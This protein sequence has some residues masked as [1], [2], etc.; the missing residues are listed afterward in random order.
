[1]MQ[2]AYLGTFRGDTYLECHRE[3]SRR[4]PILQ[5]FEVPIS[6]FSPDE[7]LDTFEAETR[8]WK[9]ETHVAGDSSLSGFAR[10]GITGCGIVNC[11]T[12]RNSGNIHAQ[13]ATTT[14]VPMPP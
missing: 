1:M 4:T 6:G 2:V 5:A 3:P 13:S 11:S 9:L 14:N 8:N 12:R 7:H 10:S